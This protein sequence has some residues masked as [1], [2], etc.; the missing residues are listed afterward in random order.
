MAPDSQAGRTL[1]RLPAH[2]GHEVLQAVLH[3]ELAQVENVRSYLGCRGDQTD[4]EAGP[5]LD[6]DNN[7]SII[8]LQE[9]VVTEIINVSSDVAS[10]DHAVQ[11]A[12]NDVESGN[13]L[14]QWEDWSQQ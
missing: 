13:A 14:R 1:L 5:R 11:A 6:I 9:G 3:L 2:S 4:P 10:V 12:V 7:V 8:D